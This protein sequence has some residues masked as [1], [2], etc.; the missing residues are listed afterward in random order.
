MAL[1]SAASFAA[2]Q[3]IRIV[4]YNIEADINGVTTPRSGLDTVLEA[5]GQEKY[6]GD[7][8]VQPLDILGLEETTSNAVT[9]APIV[10]DLNSF[11]GAGTYAQSTV[12]AT[13]SGGASSG[14]GPNAIIYNTKT[15]QL[16]DSHTVANTPTSTNAPAG[17]RVDR[18]VMRYEFEPVGGSA[19]QAFY[20][21]VSHMKSSFSDSGQDLINDESDRTLES[22][23]ILADEATLPSNACISSTPAMSSL[24][25]G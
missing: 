3:T 20:V 2:A 12:Q 17:S 15:L 10:T 16:L 18:A 25:S 6:V 14:N 1:T 4:S 19:S 7:S 23:D 24:S 13:Q 9:V 22:N 21:Y 8:V 5:I 11:Y